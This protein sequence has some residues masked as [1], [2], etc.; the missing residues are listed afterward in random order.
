MKDVR[1]LVAFAYKS[2][3]P[4]SFFN[5]RKWLIQTNEAIMLKG[6]YCIDAMSSQ[7]GARNKQ[8]V[9]IL[10]LPLSKGI[11]HLRKSAKSP[12]KIC[13]KYKKGDKKGKKKPKNL[14]N[15]LIAWTVSAVCPFSPVPKHQKYTMVC[16][17]FGMNYANLD[18]FWGS[19]TVSNWC[20]SAS[21]HY[22]P[23]DLAANSI[24]ILNYPTHFCMRITIEI[25]F[26]DCTKS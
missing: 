7:V 18:L 2:E 25:E 10:V 16:N 23:Q 26:V 21:L 4:K 6:L 11:C 15:V 22:F 5:K 19:W 13:H 24:F 1:V 9:H 3:M 17:S 14:R 8:H 12:N 20:P